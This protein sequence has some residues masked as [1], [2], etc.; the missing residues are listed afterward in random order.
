MGWTYTRRN[1]YV[2]TLRQFF[3]GEFAPCEV[4]EFATK[5]WTEA[6]AVLRSPRT[7][8]TFGLALMLHYRPKD[9]FNFGYKDMTEDMGPNIANAPVKFID[10]LDREAP[11][12]DENDKSGWARDW[13]ARCRKNAAA[14]KLPKVK[15]GDWL[16]WDAADAPEYRRG[17]LMEGKVVR[18][19]R[20]N[21]VVSSPA[22]WEY[23]VPAHYVQKAVVVGA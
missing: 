5:G 8:A 4:L 6:Y 20:S 15:V 9:D 14:R 23:R 1:K 11:L 22:G 18:K 13:R 17:K 7:G 12:N 2:E 16:Q 21:I 3:A 10:R 19:G